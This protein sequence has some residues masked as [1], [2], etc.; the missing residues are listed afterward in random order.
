MNTEDV[1]APDEPNAASHPAMSGHGTV[2]TQLQDSAVAH[3]HEDNRPWTLVTAI[4]TETDD[5]ASLLDFRLLKVAH[6]PEADG[7]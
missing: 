2:N 3:P 1:A 7:D 4:G 6:R 5:L